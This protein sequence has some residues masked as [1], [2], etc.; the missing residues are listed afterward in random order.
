MK[1]F[2]V[3]PRW[4]GS[5]LCLFYG[6]H[7]ICSL[8]PPSCH[9]NRWSLLGLF[10]INAS[11]PDW[12]LVFLSRLTSSLPLVYVILIVGSQSRWVDFPKGNRRFIRRP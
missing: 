8:G 1:F 9:S 10:Q 12:A 6:G 7:G 4:W 2:L 3:A 11:I 5:L